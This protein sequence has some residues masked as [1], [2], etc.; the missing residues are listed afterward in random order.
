MS[1]TVDQAYVNAYSNAV[2]MFFQRKGSKLRGMVREKM[3]QA[4]YE[5]F[6]RIHPSAAVKRTTRHT[7]TKHIE[8]QHSR[9]RA[10]KSDYDWPALVSK[11]DL[12]RMLIDATSSYV[13]LGGY[14]MGRALDAE[15]IEAFNADAIEGKT[16]GTTVVFPAGQK[17]AHS[18]LNMNYIKLLNTKLL[19]DDND[20]EEGDLKLV[21]SPSGVNSLLQQT[22][23]QSLDYNNVK[24]LVEGEVRTFAGF[25][26]I[27]H[28][29]LPKTG[30]I[31]QC[32]AWHPV[33]MGVVMGQEFD[34]T[35][36]RLPGKYNDIQI[37]IQGSFGAVR[38]LDE[39]VVEIS[40]DESAGPA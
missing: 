1:T 8:V 7:D 15:V 29:G 37:L 9:R 39:G 22:Q 36:D 11:N 30:N 13:T 4:E 28:T 6:E 21:L 19:F 16:G 25:T 12:H 2:T 35:V 10:E 34:T 20:I 18:S 27:K 31:R 32:F 3:T 33:A 23:V 5:F 26:F 38:V 40:I 17:V 14:A 24:A